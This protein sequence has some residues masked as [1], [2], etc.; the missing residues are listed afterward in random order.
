MGNVAMTHHEI[1][2]AERALKKERRLK[3]Q[4]L[5]KEW[6]EEYYYPRLKALR[7]ECGELGHN[8]KFGD[9]GPTGLPWFICHSC[10]M[11]KVIKD[12]DDLAGEGRQ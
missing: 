8:W 7:E 11:Q 6:D 3:I 5:M 2:V 12:D 1:W 4:E 9:L 10:G